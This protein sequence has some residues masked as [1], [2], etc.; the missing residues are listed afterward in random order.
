[1]M[2]RAHRI[3]PPGPWMFVSKFMPIT[4][5]V[6]ETF[7]TWSQAVAQAT[8]TVSAAVLLVSKTWL[9]MC[10]SKTIT[11]TNHWKASLNNLFRSHEDL[12]SCDCNSVMKHP[13]CADTTDGLLNRLKWP[14]A[15]P[16]KCQRDTKQPQRA[17]NGYLFVQRGPDSSTTYTCF[18][19]EVICWRAHIC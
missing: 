6:A 11:C 18:T 9:L 5:R 4:P 1:M 3:C 19:C 7:L 15:S 8:D 10:L 14:R 16:A 2:T 13:L 17:A 12:V